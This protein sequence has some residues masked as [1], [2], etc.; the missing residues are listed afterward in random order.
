MRSLAISRPTYLRSRTHGRGQYSLRVS[1]LTQH[2]RWSLLFTCHQPSP[3]V[4][5]HPLKSR[6]SLLRLNN[7]VGSLQMPQHR[8]KFGPGGCKGFETHAAK[9][10]LPVR[11]ILSLSLVAVCQCLPQSLFVAHAILGHITAAS[12]LPNPFSQSQ[13]KTVI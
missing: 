5:S 13:L 8:T 1:L 11:I 7:P 12:I 10:P 9:W 4:V 3:F 2:N 6:V